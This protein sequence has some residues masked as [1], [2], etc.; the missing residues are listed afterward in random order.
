[1]ASDTIP[2]GSPG[3]LKRPTDPAVADDPGACCV[4]RGFCLEVLERAEGKAKAE[5]IRC[6]AIDGGI[7]VA[8]ISRSSYGEKDG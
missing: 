3:A 2:G 6:K 1:M 4:P 7:P 8:D 5:D